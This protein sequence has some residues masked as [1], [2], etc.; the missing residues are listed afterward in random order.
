[1]KII[2][3]YLIAVL[4]RSE[5]P[6]ITALLGEKKTLAGGDTLVLMNFF[7]FL[8]ILMPVEKCRKMHMNFLLLEELLI[9]SRVIGGIFTCISLQLDGYHTVT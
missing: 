9:I 6:Q 8:S 3:F 1:M 5:V 7:F 4:W 2:K